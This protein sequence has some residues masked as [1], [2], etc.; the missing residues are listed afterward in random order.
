MLAPARWKGPVH[1]AGGLV[2]Y[3]PGIHCPWP[4]GDAVPWSN[5]F[6]ISPGWDFTK[7]HPDLELILMI[8]W[9]ISLRLVC[10]A[11]C[12]YIELVGFRKQQTLHCGAPPRSRSWAPPIFSGF[13]TSQLDCQG[14]HTDRQTDRQ[15]D[16]HTHTY[17]YI[18]RYIQ[19]YIQR[20]IHRYIDT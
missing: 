19:R 2:C 1:D 7:K 16:I 8:A 13:P 3:S 4:H 10:W 20:Y 17:T 11:Y 9:F 14:I 15:T 18:H 6:L 12:R 5:N